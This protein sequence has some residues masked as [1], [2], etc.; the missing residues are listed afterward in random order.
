MRSPG[1]SKSPKP[2]KFQLL[3]SGN[4][5]AIYG[6]SRSF[7]FAVSKT[8]GRRNYWKT[9]RVKYFLDKV[10][11]N[12]WKILKPVIVRNRRNVEF[13][14]HVV[15][16][17]HATRQVFT[18]YDLAL[19]RKVISMHAHCVILGLLLFQAALEICLKSL[20]TRTKFG[21]W[22]FCSLNRA[23]LR[24]YYQCLVNK[25][26][27]SCVLKVLKHGSDMI[28]QNSSRRMLLLVACKSH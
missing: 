12:L 5:T 17:T 27:C 4:Q 6:V 13:Y 14:T 8:Q 19:W 11:N 23:C 25:P 20:L 18:L 10:K 24:F 28:W 1:E 7:A 15:A 3:A 26:N 21:S 2:A 16:T 9:R 22:T